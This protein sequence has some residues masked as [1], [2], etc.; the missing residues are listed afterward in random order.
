MVSKKVKTKAL[1]K[2]NPK[3]GLVKEILQGVERRKDSDDF[4][5]LDLGT[6]PA[7]YIQTRYSGPGWRLE[8]RDWHKDG[9]YTHYFAHLATGSKD[10]E[11][12]PQFQV[13][14]DAFEAFYRRHPYQPDLKWVVYDI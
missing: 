3:W 8:R 14:I 13:I 5:I 1:H 11:T 2:E 4:C 12:V 9:S 7:D 6:N 10:A